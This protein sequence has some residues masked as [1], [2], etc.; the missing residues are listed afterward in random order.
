MPQMFKKN[1]LSVTE[2]LELC[3]IML[4][5]IKNM[6][7]IEFKF[8]TS[9]LFISFNNCFFRKDKFELDFEISSQ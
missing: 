2:I 6:P 1:W 9:Q 7:F 3:Q 5:V 8:I 4:L